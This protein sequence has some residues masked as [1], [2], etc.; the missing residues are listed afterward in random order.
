ML[1][2]VCKSNKGDGSRDVR[3]LRSCGN[4]M[5]ETEAETAAVKEAER[6]ISFFFWSPSPLTSLTSGVNRLNGSGDREV[7]N[8]PI[9]ILEKY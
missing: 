7:T 3:C 1:T 4:Q 8:Q 2:F 9:K 5:K 6:K